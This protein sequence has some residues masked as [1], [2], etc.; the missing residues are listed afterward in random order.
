MG[1]LDGKVA[2]ITGAGSGI[3]KASAKVFVREG[4]RMVA[5]D[6]SG[7]E[8]DTAAEVGQAVLPVHC[9]VSNDTDVA[10]LFAATLKEF[11]RVDAVINVAG[12][13][14]TRHPDV[15]SVDE[16]DR[17]TAVNLR[18]VLSV[19]QHALPLMLAGGGG[20]FVNVSSVSAIN[21]QNRTSFMYAAAKSGVHALTKS[22]A[23]EYGP[24]GIRANAIAPG[25]TFTDIMPERL[26]AEMGPKAA[27][28]RAGRPEELAEVAA[29]LA[30]DRA[31]FVTGVVIPVDGGWT[32]RLA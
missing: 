27:L 17:M 18:G 10:A 9:D 13:H 4:A 19:M 12:T 20:A 30:S 8:K 28:N 16:F 6:I 3:G 7:A 2:V 23:V 21:V 24:R 1:I 22:V 26:L 31:S 14:G 5:A 32:A 25:F 29:F 11:G 15:L